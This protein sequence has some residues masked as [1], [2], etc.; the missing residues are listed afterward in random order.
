MKRVCYYCGRISNSENI[1]CEESYCS[2]ENLPRILDHG[3]E[4]AEISIKKHI[5][6]TRS[7]TI[8]EASRY[9]EDILVKIAHTGMEKKLMDEANLLQEIQSA[10]GDPHPVLPILLP[11]HAQETISEYPYAE[12]VFQGESKT[13]YVLEHLEGD[14]LNGLLMKNS[15]PWKGTVGYISL[16][17]ASLL[18]T[19][20]DRDYVHLGLE[21]N[22]IMVRID[23]EDLPRPVVLDLGVARKINNAGRYWNRQY[24]HPAYLPP[25]L[26][27][28]P[29]RKKGQKPIINESA[30]VYGLGLIIYEMLAGHPAI[31]HYL[32]NDQDIRR[33]RWSSKIQ[34]K[35]I[36]R[37][38]IEPELTDIVMSAIGPASKRPKTVYDFGQ[39]L[40]QHF[41]PA[42]K[43]KPKTYREQINWQNVQRWV[44]ISAVTALILTT[45]LALWI[46]DVFS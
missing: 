2:T 6:V 14:L 45:L 1:W 39:S 13:F 3:E 41:D 43:E 11:A 46:N 30:D 20:H 42:P 35:K 21:P 4:L 34:V 31:P 24:V 37:P 38:D 27:P 40:L 32:M 5:A 18:I 15:Q 17:I 7:A 8:Y 25:E 29:S 36:D 19:L 10:G 44:M 9:G 33:A 16:A 23:K 26:D 12:T 22:Q 28:E